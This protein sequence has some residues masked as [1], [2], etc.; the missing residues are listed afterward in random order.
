M[1]SGMFLPVQLAAAEALGNPGSWYE[2][3]N[4]TYLERRKI[5]E[6]IMDQLGCIYN[7]KQTGLF[8]WARVPEDTAST[9]GLVDEI[10][11]QSHVFLTPGFIFGKN[12][13]R[14]FRISLCAEKAVFNEAL[15]RIK[16]Y[17]R[18]RKA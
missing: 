7:S 18:N 10:L 12:G 5:A 11:M 17:C 4:A 13:S 14:F 9:E 15:D 8:L 3:I 1:D 6:E 2:S 16:K